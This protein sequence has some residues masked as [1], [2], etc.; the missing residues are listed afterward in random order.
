MKEECTLLNVEF[1]CAFVMF[2]LRAEFVFL[3]A[4]ELNENP[5]T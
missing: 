1:R 5:L 2:N 3:C 4:N